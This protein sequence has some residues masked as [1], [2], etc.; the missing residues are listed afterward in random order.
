MSAASAVTLGTLLLALFLVLVAALVW[1]EAKRRPGSELPSYIV[2]DSV[3]FIAG[4]IRGATTLTRADVKRIIE[5][6]LFY[7]QGLAQKQRWRP[8]ETVAGGTPE[9]VDFIH[10]RIAQ[11]HHVSYPL[12][13]IRKVLELEA[14]YLH[15][16]G[17]VGEAVEE[18]DED[19][20]GDEA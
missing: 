2:E 19:E 3:N 10:G 4:R 14:G 7:L 6:N 13:E 12:E 1:Q 11:R 8:V 9:A 20:R 16:I 18:R 15:S 17:V 5:W